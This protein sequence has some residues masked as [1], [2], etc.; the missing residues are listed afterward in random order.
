MA[1]NATTT[2]ANGLG[3]LCDLEPEE[4]YE[5]RCDAEVLL[6]ESGDDIEATVKQLVSNAALHYKVKLSSEEAWRILAAAQE[7]VDEDIK[8]STGE[9]TTSTLLPREAAPEKERPEISNSFISDY[10][11]YADVIGAP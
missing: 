10:V 9:E 7:Q 3:Q 6:M 11:D 8:L 2:N 4:C 1:S 5:L